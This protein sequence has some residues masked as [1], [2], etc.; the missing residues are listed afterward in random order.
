MLVLLL[1]TLAFAWRPNPSYGLTNFKDMITTWCANVD[2][3]NFKGSR[4]A[5]LCQLRWN[6][7]GYT[8]NLIQGDGFAFQVN[9]KK[10]SNPFQ[11]VGSN[12]IEY[13]GEY[14][15]NIKYYALNSL[16][17]DASITKRYMV[18]PNKHIVLEKYDITNTGNSPLNFNLFDY[19]NSS[20]VE[21]NVIGG[22]IAST[23]ALYFDYK[24]DYT[25][26]QNTVVVFGLV[27]TDTISFGDSTGYTPVDYFNTN[28]RLDGV[29]SKTSPSMIGALQKEVI[30]NAGSTVSIL[31]YRALANSISEAEEISKEIINNSWESYYQELKSYSDEKFS[32]YKLP[33]FKNE[34]ERKMWYSSV[35]TLLYSQNPTLGT[36]VASYHPLYYYKVWSRDAVFA[37]IIM[38][39]L[40][41]TEGAEKFLKW[42]S[43]SELRDGGFFPTNYDWY[44][45]KICDFVEPQYDSVGVALTAYYYYYTQTKK[46]DLL[47]SDSVKTRIRTLEDFLMQ[48]D[49]HN[50]IKPDYSIWEESS[51]G[52]TGNSLPTQYY[53]FTQIQGHHGLLCAA[54]IEKDIYKDLNRAD[55][56]INR[57]EEISKSFDQYFWNEEGQ[58]Y[59]QAIWSD[60][61]EQK[62]VIDA[63]TATMLFSD[64]VVNQERIKKHLNKIRSD[65]TKLSYGISRYYNDPYFF[66]SKFNP[67]G[68][69]V[70]EA[71]PPWGVTTMF[72]SWAE[73][74]ADEIDGHKSLTANRIQWMIDHTGP[75]FIPCGEAV[76]GISGDPVMAS[77][78]DVYEHAGVYIM[79]VLQYQNLV[80]L[81]NYKKW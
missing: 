11:F 51:D 65:L 77:M 22:S 40:G 57:A 61:K 7:N 63:S 72:M 10:F 33:S 23:K 78:P 6:G 79:T 45:G 38:M 52:W 37:S 18:V 35:F 42:L 81:F 64:I 67:A 76:D 46:T 19:V 30:I 47:L 12:S 26:Y 69:E 14:L 44:T 56:L 73:M 54:M 70:G 41:E 58:Y 29:S 66:K 8:Q 75:D 9:G 39:A 16:Q 50:L 71:S 31:A 43:T 3:A 20:S 60:S 36:L 62:V 74:L 34:A 68:K 55:D 4:P 27:D 49:Y 32:H 1:I 25:N 48:R 2:S 15:F 80:P 24:N 28:G 17:I 21:N 53:A 5:G 13:P 59:V